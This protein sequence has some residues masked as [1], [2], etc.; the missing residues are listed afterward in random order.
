MKRVLF[1]LFLLT[2][3]GKY[4]DLDRPVSV[5]VL[6][7]ELNVVEITTYFDH[8]VR[9]LGG[10]TLPSA[11]QVVYVSYNSTGDC[12]GCTPFT[13]EYVTRHDDEIQILPHIK[14]LPAEALEH[15]ITHGLGHV[16]GYEAHL[17]S[18]RTGVMMPIYDYV[19]QPK[20]R[21]TAD[22]L[23]AIATGRV[24]GGVFR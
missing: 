14:T 5:A 21:Y 11:D 17:P 24:I 7:P 20:S 3:C 6:S 12:R 18:G 16:L 10:T 9:Q 8:A 1:T 22:D 13:F 4:W 23:A 2:G 19:P 15:A